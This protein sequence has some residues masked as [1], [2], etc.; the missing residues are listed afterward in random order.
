MPCNQSHEI[1][2]FRVLDRDLSIHRNYLLEASAGTG[3]TFAV[4]NLF[5]RLLVEAGPKGEQ[6]LELQEILAVTFTRAA[7]RDLKNRIRSK[8][9]AAASILSGAISENMPDYL[10]AI[11][12]RGAEASQK[13]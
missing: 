8:I 10:L 1:P 2:S 6:P 3:K 5:V 4:E 11:I 7:T 9:E 12:E 13:G